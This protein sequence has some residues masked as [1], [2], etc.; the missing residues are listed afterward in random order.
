MRAGAAGTGAA[1]PGRRAAATTPTGI[2]ADAD[3]DAET[4]RIR[5]ARREFA[6]LLGEFRRTPALLP[7]G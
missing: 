3:A 2:D 6:A 4:V 1:Y 5:R 7:L